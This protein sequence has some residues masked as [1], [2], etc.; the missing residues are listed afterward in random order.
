MLEKTMCATIIKEFVD[1]NKTFTAQ[2]I[3]SAIA[4]K[5]GIILE[6]QTIIDTLKTYDIPSVIIYNVTTSVV[7][8]TWH[9]Y[10]KPLTTNK[11]AS[12]CKTP[13]PTLYTTSVSVYDQWPFKVPPAL[14]NK[15]QNSRKRKPTTPT[16]T[17]NAGVK[18]NTSI[19]YEFTPRTYPDLRG[20]YTIPKTIVEAAGLRPG[21][22]VT[23]DV[24]NNRLVQSKSGKHKYTVDKNNNI[25]VNAHLIQAEDKSLTTRINKSTKEISVLY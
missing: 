17:Q 18:T 6:T 25:R 9:V 23:F 10:N 21:M 20:R 15:L 3:A 8:T 13:E 11:V 4:R 16:V 7:P 1:G 2:E 24:E 22:Q 12:C 14:K 19:N 5:T